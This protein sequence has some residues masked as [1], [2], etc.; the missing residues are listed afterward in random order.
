MLPN[1]HQV[2]L[3]SVQIKKKKS[4]VK[5]LKDNQV[6]KSGCPRKFLVVPILPQNWNNFCDQ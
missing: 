6:A 3:W 2:P 4:V 5:C 1:K